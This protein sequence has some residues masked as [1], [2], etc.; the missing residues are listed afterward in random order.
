MITPRGLAV[1]F[2]RLD[3][4][5]ADRLPTDRPFLGALEVYL[6]RLRLL[7]QLACVAVVVCVPGMLLLRLPVSAST[8]TIVSV[9]VGCLMAIRLVGL[10]LERWKRFT[11]RYERGYDP[12]DSSERI[13]RKYAMEGP[14]TILDEATEAY[15][16]T[17]RRFLVDS[18]GA[19]PRAAG[20][21]AGSQEEPTRFALEELER[22]NRRT[23][24]HT[25]TAL[26][27]ILDRAGQADFQAVSSVLEDSFRRAFDSAVGEAYYVPWAPAPQAQRS[28][29]RPAMSVRFVLKKG[30]TGT[31]RFN[32]VTPKGEIVATSEEY[33]SK[34][35]A[36][37]WIDVLRQSG[38]A[39][40]VDE[41][42]I[43]PT[44]K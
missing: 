1:G 38:A 10:E 7:A 31:F 5:T 3:L 26:D 20:F 16:Q 28:E 15:R 42:D 14:A 22:R 43:G 2:A 25:L 29:E 24:E 30:S 13:K 34:A 18:A 19:T 40:V 21:P 23:L 32:L 37:R 41:T 6:K 4:S 35:S 11:E 12:P 33:E 36:K 9:G 39:S 44:S 17:L 27:S 8:T